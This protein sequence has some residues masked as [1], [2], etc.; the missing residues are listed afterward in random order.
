M[1]DEV[2]AVCCEALCEEDEG[3]TEWEGEGEESTE[4]D[5]VA[6]LEPLEPKAGAGPGMANDLK[7]SSQISGV[8]KLA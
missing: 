6:S 2:E 5:G 1:T 3:I 4:V 8:L 7:P